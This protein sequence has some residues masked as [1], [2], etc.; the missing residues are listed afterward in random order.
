MSLSRL[1]QTLFKP[2][3]S[4]VTN[5]SGCL[6][7]MAMTAMLDKPSLDVFSKL[8]V[9]SMF[10]KKRKKAERQMSQNSHNFQD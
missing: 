8:S 4:L 5:A 6:H 3:C 7:F 10:L 9:F 2:L 1:N